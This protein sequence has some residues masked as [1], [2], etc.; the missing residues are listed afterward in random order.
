MS[1]FD[2]YILPTP[3]SQVGPPQEAL[4]DDCDGSQDDLRGHYS[5][6]ASIVSLVS[7]SKL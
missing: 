3:D 5:G 6:F 2:G 7:N 4:V 1:S